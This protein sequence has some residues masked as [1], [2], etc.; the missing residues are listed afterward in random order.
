MCVVTGG[1]YLCVV[2]S[3]KKWSG[4]PVF[5]KPKVDLRFSFHWTIATKS[6][7][8]QSSFRCKKWTAITKSEPSVAEAHEF[9]FGWLAVFPRLV[10]HVRPKHCLYSYKC[11]T[12]R[13]VLLAERMAQLCV[14]P[15][16]PVLLTKRG[17]QFSFGW[18]K[19]DL[20][21]TLADHKDL[22]KVF[23]VQLQLSEF[24]LC[25]PHACSTQHH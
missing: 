14:E 5:G 25:R 24:C 18:P 20:S 2:L 15:P 17:S 4:C 10:R 6:G 8:P 23:P 21:P 13:H 1:V 16:G 12:C 11:I 3:C 9:N 22:T 7:P 19:V